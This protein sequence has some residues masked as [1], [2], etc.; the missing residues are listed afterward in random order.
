[1][2]ATLKSFHVAP[3]RRQRDIQAGGPSEVAGNTQDHRRR[4]RRRQPGGL[5]TPSYELRF[6]QEP[7]RRLRAP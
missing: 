3:A 7:A 2:A 1:M 4:T 5:G 6:Q